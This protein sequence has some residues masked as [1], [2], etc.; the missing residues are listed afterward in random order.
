MRSRNQMHDTVSASPDRL[1]WLPLLALMA[2][3]LAAGEVRANLHQE[4]RAAGPTRAAFDAPLTVESWCRL[5]PGAPA[6]REAPGVRG[7]SAGA[8]TGPG[9]HS[10]AAYRFDSRGSRIVHAPR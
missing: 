10:L 8:E 1:I 3:A 9:V 6:G 4:A 5:H 2:V 7:A